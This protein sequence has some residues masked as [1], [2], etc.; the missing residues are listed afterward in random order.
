MAWDLRENPAMHLSFKL[1][2]GYGLLLRR[3]SYSTDGLMEDAHLGKIQSLQA[4]S[5]RSSTDKFT[6]EIATLDEQGGLC[7]WIVLELERGLVAGSEADLCLGIGSKVK[8]FKNFSMDLSQGSLMRCLD[9]EFR[10][11]NTNDMILAT[12]TG[13]VMHI[14]KHGKASPCEY[15]GPGGGCDA[16][17]VHFS[18]F[19]P[20]YFLA[21]YGNGTVSLYHEDSPVSI[22]SW[23]D[24]S[25]HQIVEAMWLPSKPQVF[26]VYNIE[27]EIF[28]FNLLQDPHSPVSIAQLHAKSTAQQAAL[29]KVRASPRGV[30]H[31]FMATAF[32]NGLVNIHTLSGI[33]SDSPISD[34]HRMQAFLEGREYR[35]SEYMEE[36]RDLHE[37][38]PLQL[39]AEFNPYGADEIFGDMFGV[40]G[41]NSRKAKTGRRA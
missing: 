41:S 39:E 25:S 18:P 27:R 10:P 3:P 19:L 13:H 14:A 1:P 9:M 32:T 12:G 22:Y 6:D 15:Q 8:I 26:V 21:A 40:V 28:V 33:Y 16:L 36:E 23:A 7:L 37:E 35:E 34:V 4:L 5:S 20:A 17:T 31:S 24:F 2:G 29:C 30:G 11:G 38:D